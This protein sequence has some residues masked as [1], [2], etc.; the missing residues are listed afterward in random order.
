[1][2]DLLFAVPWYLPTVLG[3]IGLAI[4]VSGNRRQHPPARMAGLVVIVL[5][6][7]WAV[8]SYLVDTPK[9]ICEKNSRRLVQSVV[10][11]DWKTFGELLAPDAAFKFAGTQWQIAGKEDLTN[12]VKASV[13]PIGLK[14]ASVTDA[15]A[16]ESG[17]TITVS[18]KVFSTQ[19]ISLDRPI[20]SQ[21]ELDWQESGGRWLLHEIRAIQVTGV[22]PDQVRG[23]LREK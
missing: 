5:A 1:M 18:I 16:K 17:S 15:V 22:T 19:E 20:D 9:E 23:G 11:R 2:R 8:M 10:D 12:R 7:G 14:S 3:I 4:F 21:W 6:I 13:E